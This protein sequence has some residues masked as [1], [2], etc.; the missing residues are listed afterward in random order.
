MRELG[1]TANDGEANSWTAFLQEDQKRLSDAFGRDE[2]R[3][4]MVFTE[5]MLRMSKLARRG[6]LRALVR[7]ARARRVIV[8]EGEKQASVTDEPWL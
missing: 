8:E 5:K 2:Q 3:Q 7:K 1:V 4:K 6:K